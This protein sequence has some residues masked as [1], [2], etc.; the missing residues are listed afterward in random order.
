MTDRCPRP[1]TRTAAAERGSALVLALLVTVILAL[2]GISFLLLAETE[3][4]IAQ[5]E[6]RA[7]QALYVAEAGLIAVK[8]WFDATGSAIGFPESSVVDRTLRVTIDET[9]PYD[10][11]AAQPADGIV[12]SRPYY[13]QAVDLDGDGGDDLFDKPYR[14]DDRHRF[15]GTPDGPDLRIDDG[16]AAGRTFLDT[17][18]ERLFGGF[19]GEPG[20]VVARLSR[21]DLYAPPYE[22]VGPGWRRYGLATVK[23][24]ARLYRD[25]GNE[26]EVLAEHQ[27]EGVVSEIPY[28]GPHAPLHS[29]GPATFVPQASGEMTVRW[30]AL[31]AVGDVHTADP[32]A[33][34]AVPMSVPRTLPFGPGADQ[35]F[36]VDET[37]FD[38]FKSTVV[39][40]LPIQDPWFRIVAGGQ[41]EA[42]GGAATQP[43]PPSTTAN[44]DHSNLMQ[45]LGVVMCPRYDYD[46]W[47]NIATSGGRNVRYFAYDSASGGFRENGTGNSETLQV[48]TDGQEGIFFFDTRD[49]HPP[50]DADADGVFDNLTPAMVLSGAW[51]FSGFL[52]VNATKFEVSDVSGQAREIRPPGEPYLDLNEN[53]KYDAGERY[54]NLD[55]AT[56]TAA[57][58][59][60]RA[61]DSSPGSAVRDA[62]GPAIPDVPVSF[63][64]ILYT[65]GRFESVGEGTFYGTVVA[66]QW[67]SQ[68][69]S[70]G[71][72]PTPTLIWDESIVSGWPPEG[73]ALPR[74]LITEWDSGG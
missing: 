59:T 62:R 1:G 12:G 57:S 55:Y 10:A 47:K 44:Q 72:V 43:V 29:C 25:P 7:A 63:R 33:G 24:T 22:R 31:S 42:F 2:L 50:T 8:H 5:N 52:Y 15:L 27:I 60:V 21:I 49:G 45:N 68:S 6:K 37:L 64:G 54:V 65:T 34:S 18:S 40:D 66:G 69:P 26:R 56:A 3:N 48:L 41:I 71:S 51:D 17:L 35:L 16:D 53:G 30:G 20:G 70:D 61:D 38:L 28:Q 58:A 74:V 36:P 9:D 23:V 11:A 32:I 73:S 67:V 13:K 4:R 39:L 19:P 14:G 46:L